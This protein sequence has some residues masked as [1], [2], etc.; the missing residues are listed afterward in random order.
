M[1]FFGVDKKMLMQLPAVKYLNEK[2][3][4]EIVK[5]LYYLHRMKFSFFLLI[6]FLSQKIFGQDTVKHFW[7]G[8]SAG[9][10]PEIGYSLGEDRLGSA[11]MGYIDT[12]IIL[13]IIDSADKRYKIQLSKFHSAYIAKA[14]VA[15][16]SVYTEK[17]FYLTGNYNAIGGTADYDTLYIN[18]SEKLPYKSWM[19]INPSRIIVELYGVQ[20][21]TSWI[22]Q[23]ISSLKEIKNLYYNQ[24]EDDMVCVTIELQ[25]KQ[26]WGYTIRYS[27]TR[28]MVLVK[29]QPPV[30]NI[31]K[32]KIAVDAGHGGT[33][34]GAAGNTSGIAEKT[35]TLI[36][37]NALQKYLK[38][39]GVKNVI[40][41]RTT[42]TTIGNTDRVLWLQKQQPDLL[43]SL[44][45]NSSDD[46]SVNGTGTFYKHIGFRTLS[47]AL[48]K[49]MLEAKMNEYGNV[50]NFN[51]LLNQP[52]DFPNALLEI[53]FLSNVQDEKKIRSANFQNLTA[54]KVYAGIVDFL[55]QSK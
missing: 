23:N 16:D 25:N 7:Y 26:H 41:T 1:V 30:L 47:I 3:E 10:L 20:S 22:T 32:L 4:S 42:D 27:G 40:M 39:K 19:E 21:N 28:L 6:L 37:A 13:K 46:T 45:L 9:K 18:G 14:D 24:A 49:E 5:Q 35:Y 48:L 55:N 38:A 8:R 50:G 53:A 44:H 12:G 52:T 2:S 33:N 54:A 43:I 34:T 15:R 51:F 17:P 29:R 11:K 36:F 31:Q